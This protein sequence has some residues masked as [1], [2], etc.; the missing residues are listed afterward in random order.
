VA[1]KSKK[2][3]TSREGKK[4]RQGGTKDLKKKKKNLIKEPRQKKPSPRR[5]KGPKLKPSAGMGPQKKKEEDSG[6]WQK[7]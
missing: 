3:P 6:R 7:K 5:E 4:N 2:A 1:G